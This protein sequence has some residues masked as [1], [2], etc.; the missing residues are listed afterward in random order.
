MHFRREFILVLLLIS[1]VIKYVIESILALQKLATFQHNAKMVMVAVFI[2][3]SFMVNSRRTR[4]QEEQYRGFLE[5]NLLE[6]DFQ[7]WLKMSI[8]TFKYLCTLFEN[9]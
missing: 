1:I 9:V 2:A 5:W 8:S 4:W 3:G 7:K 6:P